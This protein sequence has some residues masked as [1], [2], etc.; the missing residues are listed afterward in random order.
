MRLSSSFILKPRLT[1]TLMMPALAPLLPMPTSP[2]TSRSRVSWSTTRSATSAAAQ[3]RAIASMVSPL[4]SD[5]EIA[6]ELD[7]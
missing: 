7:S 1:P 3:W 4:R 6:R 5:R 2:T